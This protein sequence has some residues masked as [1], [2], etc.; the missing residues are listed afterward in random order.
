MI[1]IEECKFHEKVKKIIKKKLKNIIYIIIYILRK[2][3]KI[4]LK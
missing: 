1:E 4:L 2:A 3:K